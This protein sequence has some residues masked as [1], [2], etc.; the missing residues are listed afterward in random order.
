ME[1]RG[2]RG[3]SDGW[4]SRKREPAFARNGRGGWDPL[5][6]KGAKQVQAQW[7]SVPKKWTDLATSGVGK[8]P[9]WIS[10]RTWSYAAPPCFWVTNSSLV[11]GLFVAAKEDRKKS[12]VRCPFREGGKWL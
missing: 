4:R 8:S 7:R 2:R 9:S 12:G 10:V 5:A 1:C 11:F 6:P 3:V